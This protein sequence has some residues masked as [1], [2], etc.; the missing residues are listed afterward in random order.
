MNDSYLDDFYNY[1]QNQKRYSINTILA[2]KRDLKMFFDYIKKENI[3]KLNTL[4]IQGY[5]SSLY[6]KNISMRTISRKL[7][8][9]KSYGKYIRKN[10]NIDTSFLDVITLPKR[11][12]KLPEYLHEDELD[13][14]LNLPINTFLELRNLLIIHLLYSTGLR[15]SELTNLKV[16]ESYIY[17][18]DE[19][20]F[21][22]IK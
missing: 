21:Y 3:K 17:S 8:A 7:S 14:L 2:Y 6:I 1:L 18:T 11:Q 15:L 9:L 19:N 5:F 13:V 10:K 22:E 20:K 4:N 16:K 12:K